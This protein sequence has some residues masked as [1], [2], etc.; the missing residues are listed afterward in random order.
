MNDN[1]RS[2]KLCQSQIQFQASVDRQPRAGREDAFV[3][4]DGYS[5][6]FAICWHGDRESRGSICPRSRPLSSP[7]TSGP[8]PAAAWRTC[9]SG[10]ACGPDRRRTGRDDPPAAAVRDDRLRAVGAR[11]RLPPRL[12]PAGGNRRCSPTASAWS[13]VWAIKLFGPVADL[14]TAPTGLGG[15]DRSCASW[16]PV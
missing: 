9:P 1:H 8:A 2:T 12:V 16:R 6:R 4:S 7:L 5:S 13:S 11:L 10:R 15:Q 3:D 14:V